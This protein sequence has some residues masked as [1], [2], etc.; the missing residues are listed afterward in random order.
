MSL[1]SRSTGQRRHLSSN[2]TQSAFEITAGRRV[3]GAAG[4]TLNSAGILTLTGG[5]FS[6]F[7]QMIGLQGY[8][9]GAFEFFGTGADDSTFNYRM[10][11]VIGNFSTNCP[12]AFPDLSKLV[13]I[14]L[15]CFVADTSTVTLSTAVGATGAASPAILSTERIADT[16]TCT[17]STTA[18]TPTGPATVM[19]TA[20]ALGDVTA[21]SPA[22]NTPA[23]LIVPDFGCVL[24]VIPEF[25]LTGATGANCLYELRK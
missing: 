12:Q 24:G 20:Y 11:L 18:T 10:W 19:Q 25:D 23:R 2:S 16:L 1:L 13:D 6:A 9:G 15:L 17:I 5:T 3:S 4:Y 22:G 8:R 7:H 14:E 21:Y